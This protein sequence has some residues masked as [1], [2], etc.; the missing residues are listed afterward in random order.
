MFGF[1][2]GEVLHWGGFFLVG[3]AC[4]AWIRGRNQAKRELHDRL[5]DATSRPADPP[6][7]VLRSADTGLPPGSAGVPPADGGFTFADTTADPWHGQGF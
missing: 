5:V 6:G 3:A 2:A 7:L 1:I 4:G